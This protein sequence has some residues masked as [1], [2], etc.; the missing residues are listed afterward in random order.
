MTTL[1]EP[2]AGAATVGRSAPG[3]FR[4][5]LATEPDVGSTVVQGARIGFSCWGEADDPGIVL[6]HGGGAHAGWWDHIAPWFSGSHR[7]VAIDL[8][9]HGDSDHRRHYTLEMWTEEVMSVARAADVSGPYVVV[10]HSMGG[11]VAIAAAA[12]LGHELAGVIAVDS[13][14]SAPDPEMTSK[15]LQRAGRS[16]RAYQTLDEIVARFRTIP[17]QAQYLDYVIEHV[18]RRSARHSQEG[19]QWKYDS[20][21]FTQFAS[22]LREFALPYLEQVSCRF[23]LLAAEHGLVTADVSEAMYEALGRAAPIVALPD[24]GH[25]PMLDQPLVL[26][27]SIRALLADWQHSI[28]RRRSQAAPI[29]SGPEQRATPPADLESARTC[30]A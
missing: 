9:G 14:V 15:D 16:G 1:G 18:A 8:S 23:A 21:I 12:R 10:G 5:A 24:S 4:R 17:P 26:V 20:R 29:P 22:G 6:V 11:F 3:W 28:P 25:H 13:P 27:A 2:I 7:V 30:N 19:W